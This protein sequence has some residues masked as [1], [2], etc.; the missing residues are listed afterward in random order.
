MFA[1]LLVYAINTLDDVN[2]DALKIS[3]NF[4]IKIGSKFQLSI[5]DDRIL[6]LSF[7][8]FRFSSVALT[9]FFFQCL[10]KCGH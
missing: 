7:L 9:H 1:S 5:K 2:D 3:H 8:H 10:L 6:I 4:P